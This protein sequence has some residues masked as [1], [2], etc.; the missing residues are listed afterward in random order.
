MIENNKENE[1]S[2]DNNISLNE[3]DI[4]LTLQNIIQGFGL[5]QDGLVS[6]IEKIKNGIKTIVEDSKIV[7]ISQIVNLIKSHFK[8]RKPFE[9][10]ETSQIR[11][12]APK[13]KT[14]NTLY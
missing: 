3:G 9:K 8:I 12:A 5:K 14:S 7:L 4:V 10:T 13:D 2:L 1:I 6:E 11:K